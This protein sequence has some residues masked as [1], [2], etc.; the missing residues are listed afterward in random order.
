[1]VQFSLPKKSK[2]VQGKFYSAEVEQPVAI[3]Y[4]WNIILSQVF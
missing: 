3:G 4:K 2:V 1:M